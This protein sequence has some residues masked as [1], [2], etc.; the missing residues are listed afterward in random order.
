MRRF[1]KFIQPLNLLHPPTL[2]EAGFASAVQWYI[3]GFA[4][5]SGIKI[6]TDFAPGAER[7]PDTIEIALF[8]V[9]QESLTNVHSG[10][11]DVDI[12]FRREAHTAILEVRDYG[13]GLPNRWLGHTGPPVQ[14]FGVGLAGMRERLNET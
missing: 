6:R 12:R 8:R 13:C 10:T 2:D 5:R 14:E 1:R 7:L 11:S 3:D 9:L 4:K